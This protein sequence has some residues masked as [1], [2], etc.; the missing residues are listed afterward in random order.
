VAWFG[1]P[2]GMPKKE[3]TRSGRIGFGPK[4]GQSTKGGSVFAGGRPSFGLRTKKISDLGTEISQFLK[5]N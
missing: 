2:A 5:P 3:K 4:N 1:I